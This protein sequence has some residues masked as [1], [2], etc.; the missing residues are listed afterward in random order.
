MSSVLTM[1]IGAA[2]AV[3]LSS[4]TYA[5]ATTGASLAS[6]AS[7]GPAPTYVAANPRCPS[8][9]WN[10]GSTDQGSTNHGPSYTMTPGYPVTPRSTVS[11]KHIR[12]G[13]KHK[14]GRYTS[15]GE[16]S[17]HY[18]V[19]H[20]GTGGSNGCIGVGSGSEAVGGSPN[21]GSTTTSGSTT[22]GASTGS[23]SSGATT[24]GFGS[25]N[26]S[27]GGFGR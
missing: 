2:T 1:T 26:A 25:G 14:H 15:D 21:V 22:S 18:R 6:L 3:A 24:G 23:A 8:D 11:R 17:G 19:G 4:G 9:I 5:P 13:A 12:F 20:L 27:T 16:T 7:T 10:Q